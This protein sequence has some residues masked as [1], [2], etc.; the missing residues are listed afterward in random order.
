[1]LID[2][3]VKADDKK[4]YSYEAF[5]NSQ[6]QDY[7]GGDFGPPGGFRPP[8]GSAPPRGGFEVRR[9]GGFGGRGGGPD[10]GATP[11]FKRF[12][13]ERR[14]YLL[15]HPEIDKPVSVIESVSHQVAGGEPG[16][17]S[18]LATESVLVKAKM[19]GNVEVDSVILYY[20]RGSEMPFESLI[21]SGDG[22]YS[23]EI[24]SCPAGT[25]VHYYVEAHSA[26]S[27][28]TVTFAPS[29]AELSTF[30]YQVAA[31][32]AKSSPVLINELMASNTASLTD[33]QGE[34]EDWIELFNA[35]DKEVDLSGMYLSD[36]QNNLRKWAFPENT[37]ISPGEYLI[38][39]ADEDG[40][41]QPGL[42]ANFKL[43][44]SGEVV[45]LIDRD[46]RGNAILDV[47]EFGSQQDDVSIGRLPDG[48]GNFRKLAMTP[49]GRNKL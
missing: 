31:P 25:V 49:G 14:E 46:D 4:L 22:V 21:M 41:D 44:K 35:S 45:L 11:S 37:V 32:I 3:E 23:G 16:N 2:A 28:R 6:T 1:L 34:Y 27:V 30:T 48:T 12:V 42:H 29:G 24:P 17:V 5:A 10:G 18:P 20:A 39:W 9:R 26:G 13:E 15:K 47:V 8:D 36:K 7:S 33:P 40:K 43:S 38:V 19:G